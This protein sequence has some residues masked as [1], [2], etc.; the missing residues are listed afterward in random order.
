MAYKNKYGITKI[1]SKRIDNFSIGWDYR[2][3]DPNNK[4]DRFPV[5]LFTPDMEDTKNHYHIVLDRKQSKILKKWLEDFLK[6]TKK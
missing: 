6:D 4:R 3:Y 5:F 2:N 1:K